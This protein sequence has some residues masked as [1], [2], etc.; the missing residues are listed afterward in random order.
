MVAVGLDHLEQLGL[1]FLPLVERG[2][3]ARDHQPAVQIT[4]VV[5]QAAGPDLDRV[6]RPPEREQRVA[7]ADE[8]SAG[9]P[10]EGLAQGVELLR[11]RRWAYRYHPAN[12]LL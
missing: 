3:G 7:Q 8:E 10:S 6:A 11:R 12:I 5:L 2:E 4:G 9:I 1:G